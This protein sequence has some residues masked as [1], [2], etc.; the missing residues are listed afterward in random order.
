MY[1][2]LDITTIG[3]GKADNSSN[4]PFERSLIFCEE[5]KRG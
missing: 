3:R 5:I 1:E 4:A 2:S